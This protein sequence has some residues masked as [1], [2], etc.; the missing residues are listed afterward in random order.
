MQPHIT[1][2]HLVACTVARWWFRVCLL[3][4]IRPP[5]SPIPHSWRSTIPRQ[6]PQQRGKG[7]ILFECG[8]GG[9]R[10]GVDAFFRRGGKAR[11]FL[12]GKFGNRQQAIGTARSE[13]YQK[14]KCD[15]RR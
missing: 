11:D 15:A 8:I 5:G 9:L 2:G 7:L 6:K 14:V 10:D 3:I 12:P 4:R 13:A 1:L